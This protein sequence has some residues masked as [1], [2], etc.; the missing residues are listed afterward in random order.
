[1]LFNNNFGNNREKQCSMAM[2]STHC[3]WDSAKFTHICRSRTQ[4]ASEK[5]TRYN[6][7]WNIKINDWKRQR[8]Q[9]SLQSLR[10]WERLLKTTNRH[11]FVYTLTDCLSIVYLLCPF[12]FH[13]AF[14]LV[15]ER[16]TKHDNDCTIRWQWFQKTIIRHFGHIQHSTLC[17]CYILKDTYHISR[18]HRLHSF[19]LKI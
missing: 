2:A 6:R 10:E 19:V 15:N 3:L 12:L 11:M 13:L 17:Y 7:W 8:R 16:T 5:E 14:M 4:R 1:M 18:R 9:R